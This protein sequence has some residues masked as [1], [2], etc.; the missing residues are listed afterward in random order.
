MCVNI[1]PVQLHIPPAKGLFASNHVSLQ[2]QQQQARDTQ[3][4]WN[5]SSCTNTPNMGRL[6]LSI[7]LA[8][9]STDGGNQLTCRI[10][11]RS[12]PPST[13]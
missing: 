12:S 10:Q 1:K 2:S 11:R 7:N 3:S 6:W 9:G 13:E 5:K 4:N 8:S